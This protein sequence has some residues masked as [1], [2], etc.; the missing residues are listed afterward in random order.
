MILRRLNLPKN[1]T[2]SKLA[3][4]L[5]L[6]YKWLV[7][8]PGLA[9]FTMLCGGLAFLLA[10]A[11]G[12][13]RAN[14]MGVIWSRI[15]A[16]LTPMH[17]TT[18]GF[19]NLK[20]GRSY[21]ICCNH[22]SHFDVFVL[23]GWFPAPFKWVMK[24]ELRK[25]P[26][27]GAACD[28]LGH[29]Y[30]DRSDSEKAVASINAARERLAGGE[31]ILFFPEGTRSRDGKLGRFKKGAF[32]LALDMGLPILPVTILGTAKILPAHTMELFPGDAH[33]II[34][35]PVETAGCNENDLEKLIDTVHKAI[36]SRLPN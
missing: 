17:V 27:L 28:K 13:K 6:P 24:M 32:K 12:P 14:I 23:Y 2:E 34:S 30:I 20:P 3:R 18:E 5:Y 21:V 4:I 22:S 8:M 31:S 16:R 26:F 11:A 10:S 33:M 15:M 25:V 35:P 1:F 9:F 19:D 36:A 7:F 29:I